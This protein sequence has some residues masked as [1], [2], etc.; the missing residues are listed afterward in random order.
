MIF[1]LVQ[2]P[3]SFQRFRAILINCR[4]IKEIIEKKAIRVVLGTCQI[5]II[6]LFA[7]KING[8]LMITFCEHFVNLYNKRLIINHSLDNYK[9]STKFFLVSF[10]R[11]FNSFHTA[12]GFFKYPE[13]IK[14]SLVLVFWC[15]QGVWK[16][17]G[18]ELG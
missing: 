18:M 1:Q 17:G 3:P 9:P 10:P 15:F 4:R 8:F 11:S 7:T 6:E 13:N 5:S 12:T 2:C 16:R 14:K